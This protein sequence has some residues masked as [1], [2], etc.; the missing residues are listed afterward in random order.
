MFERKIKNDWENPEI[1]ERNREIAHST[2]IPYHDVES[3][4]NEKREDSK[5]FKS[6]NGK[7]KFNYSVAPWMVPENFFD[8]NFDDRNWK[9]IKVPGNWQ[10]YGYDKPQYVNRD[11]P[12]PCDPPYLPDYN[13]VG[14]YRYKFEISKDWISRKTFIVFE[15][16]DSAFNLYI[17]GK[18]VGYSQ[19]SHMS[20]E[21]DITGFVHRGKNILAVNV[22]KWCDGSYLEDQD[23]WRLSGIFR[24]VYI[25]SRSRQH[26]KDFFVKTILDNSC[27]DAIL[28]MNIDFVDN[29]SDCLDEQ[30]LQIKLFNGKETLFDKEFIFNKEQKESLLK[31]EESIINPKK[32]SAEEP[33]LYKL[34]LI[35]NDTASNEKEVICINVGFRKIEVKNGQF[36]INNKSIKLKGVNRHEFHPDSGFYLPVEYMINDIKLMKQYN[37]N[38]VRTS[39]Y[40][41]D[42]IWYDLCDKYGIYLIDEADLETHGFKVIEGAY[43]QLSNNPAW[44]KAFIDRAQ[45]MIERDK[46]H[47]SVIIWSLGN[48]SGFGPNHVAM[49]EWIRKRDDTRPIHYMHALE[50]EC[51][52][53]I[54]RMYSEVNFLI[55]QGEK[56]ENRPF[57]L[58]E[59]CHSMGNGPG[60][61]KEY[62]DV[63]Y[64]YPRLIGGCVWEWND[65]GIR[66]KTKDGEE[67][68]A[69]GGDFGDTPN[70]INF[71]IDGMVSPDRIPHPALIEYKKV[72]EPVIIKPLNLINGKFLIENRYDF[73]S[74]NHL[75]LKWEF[76]EDNKL[77]KRGEI[78]SIEIKPGQSSE[79]LIPY[80]IP[81]KN[82][83]CEYWVN[84]KFSL[85]KTNLW[86]EK[87]HV[88]AYSQFK[89]PLEVNKLQIINLNK[90]PSL[91]LM[92]TKHEII[93]K[94]EEFNVKFNRFTGLITSYIY[95]KTELIKKGTKFNAWRA[96]TDNDICL[97]GDGLA[98]EWKFAGLDK[99]E[100]SLRD[101]E[102]KEIHESVIKINIIAVHGKHSIKPSFGTETSYTIYGNGDIIISIR[103]IP[104]KKI[105]FLARLGLQ[106]SMPEGFD[107]FSWYGRGPHEN[108]CDRKESALVGVYSG[109]VDEQF[110]NYIFPQENGNK[111]D[112]RWALVANQKGIGLLVVGQPLFETSV[113]HY[114][115]E[116]LTDAKHTYD[117]IRLNETILNI[118]YRQGGLGSNS[119]GPK[120][121]PQYLLKPEE[122]NFKVILKAFNKDKYDPMSLSK[123]RDE[124]I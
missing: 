85:E 68:F 11:Y 108:Y 37:I 115:T 47:P 89:I 14:S 123:I 111:S 114:S 48:E 65:H 55:E 2:I 81:M 102:I 120:P 59:Y 25:L 91:D 7:W 57:F 19:G 28:S 92:E 39:H 22:Y 50:D 34:L 5:Y 60:N 121:L 53:I 118:D 43:S 107:Y 124:I 29:C 77:I 86:A 64:K 13:P 15:G 49:S 46:N 21:F 93:L 119:C 33:N 26:V 99:L 63:I 12:F 10:L 27:A 44:E 30:R 105:P 38:T 95:N 23:K 45:R 72:I 109:T 35:L 24:D 17:N 90:I 51:V 98:K 79:I 94:S 110:V 71:C 106:L 16:V 40:P 76:I 8:I 116:N 73:L 80:K 18:F 122:V 84:I 36:F 78:K 3:A 56:K 83:N 41:D 69:Y 31:I 103:I 66:C 42:P 32:W 1:L 70:D 74:L 97:I 58:N 104:I 61:F 87:D 6:L 67:Y 82:N 52:D 54:C 117:L 62:W 75:V 88:I 113:R 112:V 4:I 101:M 20:S 96:P 100:R 9:N